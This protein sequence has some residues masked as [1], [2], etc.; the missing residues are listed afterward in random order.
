MEHLIKHKVTPYSASKGK[1]SY[2]HVS[3]AGVGFRKV[4]HLQR[5]HH[6]RRLD[7]FD[8]ATDPTNND[9]YIN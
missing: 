4:I 3:T 8:M 1:I 6:I 2:P 5:L 7:L 9:T